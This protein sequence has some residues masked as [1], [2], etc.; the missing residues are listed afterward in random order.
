MKKKILFSYSSEDDAGCI[1]TKR[2]TKES[3]RA[4]CMPRPGCRIIFFSLLLQN[5]NAFLL[6]PLPMVLSLFTWP[7][8]DTHAP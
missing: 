7:D 2:K 4:L 1:I 3:C 8:F 5:T 6:L